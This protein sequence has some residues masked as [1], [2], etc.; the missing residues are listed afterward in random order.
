VREDWI[1]LIEGTLDAALAIVCWQEC[2]G[3]EGTKHSGK[4]GCDGR[5]SGSVM[6]ELE[7]RGLAVLP[8]FCL[9]LDRLVLCVY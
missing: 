5:D 3:Q 7:R 8:K 9:C 4:R 2:S 1:S 6:L